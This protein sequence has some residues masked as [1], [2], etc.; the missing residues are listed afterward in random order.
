MRMIWAVPLVRLRRGII[1][2]RSLSCCRRIVSRIRCR[3]P[4]GSTTVRIIAALHPFR[5]EEL[6]QVAVLHALPVSLATN[7]LEVG[8]DGLHGPRYRSKSCGDTSKTF[9]R[10]ISI[11]RHETIQ[12]ISMGF[13]L[14][15]NVMMGTHHLNHVRGVHIMDFKKVRTH[16]WYR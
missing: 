5:A 3:F 14:A 8:S 10:K 4:L 2:T 15:E 6:Y 11:I 13:A 7:D 1:T 12:L 9:L 16:A